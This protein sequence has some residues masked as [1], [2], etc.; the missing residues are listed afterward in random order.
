MSVVTAWAVKGQVC[1]VVWL[2]F[3]IRLQLEFTNHLKK[4]TL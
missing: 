4:T 3:V 2:Q 1:S